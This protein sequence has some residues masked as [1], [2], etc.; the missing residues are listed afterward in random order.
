VDPDDDPVEAEV[1]WAVRAGDVEDEF[2]GAK[3]QQN[4]QGISLWTGGGRHSFRGWKNALPGTVVMTLRLIESNEALQAELVASRKSA[5]KLAGDQ[6]SAHAVVRKATGQLRHTRSPIK[7]TAASP[8]DELRPL[9]R[10]YRK[11]GRE[12]HLLVLL[13]VH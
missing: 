12:P 2:L 6:I 13:A 7:S 8:R 3:A 11:E 10:P 1:R 9:L 5:G 4:W